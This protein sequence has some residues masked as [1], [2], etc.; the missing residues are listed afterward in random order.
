ML[1]IISRSIKRPGDEV[2][3]VRKLD[4]FVPVA[5]LNSIV[6]TR[7]SPIGTD[8][9]HAARNLSGLTASKTRHV[10]AS[11]NQPLGYL[12]TKPCRP[13]ENECACHDAQ[14]IARATLYGRT[15]P[16]WPTSRI[17]IALAGPHGQVYE[18]IK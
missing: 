4:Y 12:A 7:M 6:S 5:S 9:S 8:E 2:G 11:G 13:T 16:S 18:R 3:L 14:L 10:L 15:A 17:P 1:R